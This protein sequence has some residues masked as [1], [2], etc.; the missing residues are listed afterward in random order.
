MYCYMLRKSLIRIPRTDGVEYQPVAEIGLGIILR[1][2]GL[3]CFLCTRCR[4]WKH[5]G[6]CVR[7]FTHLNKNKQL[8]GVR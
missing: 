7:L 5:M 8:N 1:V 6:H 2:W 4:T 3:L